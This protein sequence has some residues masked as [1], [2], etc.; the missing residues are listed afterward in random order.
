MKRFLFVVVSATALVSCGKKEEASSIV[1]T[2]DNQ[3]TIKMDTDLLDACVNGDLDVV[4]R[5]IAFGADL[6]QRTT[7]GQNNTPLILAVIFGHE[8]VVGALIGAG[9]EVNWKRPDGVTALHMAAILGYPAIVKVLIKNGADPNTRNANGASALD[10][11]LVPWEEREKILNIITSIIDSSVS[12]LDYEKIKAAHLICA[13]ILKENGAEVSTKAVRLTGNVKPVIVS[14]SDAV[15]Y[16]DLEETKKFITEGAEINVPRPDDGSTPLHIAT[17]VCNIEIV[18]ALIAAG[19]NVNAKNKKG[20]TPLVA[21]TLK[22]GTMSF[23]YGMLEGAEDKK[24]DLDRIRKDREKIAEILR[25]A[26]AK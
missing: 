22:W 3:P 9:A 13:K 5:Q 18:Q 4:K 1:E 20:E 11:V 25:A 17:L 19:A 23:V 24:F 15:F 16:E 26:G 14:L 21:V 2:G 8:E 10:S 7:D 12:R 6:N